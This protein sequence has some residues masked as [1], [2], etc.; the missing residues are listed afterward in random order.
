VRSVRIRAALLLLAGAVALAGCGGGGGDEQS[1]NTATTDTVV[2]TETVEAQPSLT[3]TTATTPGISPGIG[4]TGSS[5]IVRPFALNSPWNTEIQTADLDPNSERMMREA[6]R[7]IGAVDVG[8]NGATETTRRFLDDP[9]FINL[10]RWTTPVVD[11]INGVDT[12]VFCR[13]PPL[14]PLPPGEPRTV[15]DERALCG[16][17]WA[18]DSL[19]IPA[20]ESPHPEFDGWFTVLNRSEGIAYDLWRARRAADGGSLSYQFM[21]IWDLNGPGFLAPGRVSARGS[22]L[23]LFAGLI[24]P[25]EIEAGRIDHALAISVPAPAQRVYVQPASSTDG[26]GRVTSLPEGARIRLKRGVTFRSIQRRYA[27]ARC[28]NTLY[29]LRFRA[30]EGKCR[31]FRFQTGTNQKAAAAIITALHRYGAIVVDR[32][33]VPTLY[34]KFNADWHKPLRD[35]DG[36][37]LDA[38]GNPFP[39]GV[40]RVPTPLLRGNELEGLKLSDFEVTRTG[41]QFRFPALGTL[42]APPLPGGAVGEPEG[43]TTTPGTRTTPQSQQTFRPATTTSTTTTTEGG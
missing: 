11:E 40:K 23:P 21:R 42:T 43:T 7:R 12:P 28:N 8:G 20:D 5:G 33:S 18:V 37:L 30:Q 9:L 32:S 25:E 15:P 1:T 41:E 16:D 10:R 38:R 36:I 19:L 24:L 14:P 13:Q 2:Q 34:G 29:R 6:R 39:R 26:I 35:P 22:G 31:R 3:D 4:S 17:G 27:D